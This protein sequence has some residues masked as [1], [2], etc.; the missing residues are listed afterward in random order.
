METAYVGRFSDFLRRHGMEG[1][2][3]L[4]EN[5]KILSANRAAEA[6]LGLSLIHI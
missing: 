2:L 4:A 1:V 6:L 3:V 5:G